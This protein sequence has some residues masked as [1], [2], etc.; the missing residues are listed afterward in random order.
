MNFIKHTNPETPF[1]FDLKFNPPVPQNKPVFNC[2]DKF[3][4]LLTL[5]INKG[6]SVSIRGIEFSLTT[7]FITEDSSK[8]KFLTTPFTMKLTEA[9]KIESTFQTPIPNCILPHDIQTYHGESFSIRHLVRIIVKKSLGHVEHVQEIIAYKMTPIITEINP[10]CVSVAVSENL[11]FDLLLGRRIFDIGAVIIG[12]VH[13]KLVSLKI[14]QFIVSLLSQEVYEP[15]KG[16][17]KKHKYFIKT[18]EISDGAPVKGEIIPFRLFLDPLDI[19]PSNSDTENGYS[20]TH[21]LHFQIM[22]EGG[23]KYFK[24]FQINLSK[25]DKLPYQFTDDSSVINEKP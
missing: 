23:N 2:G 15:K 7:E 16:K 12:A 3:D 18:W 6:S 10:L 13:F 9:I 25:W 8:P 20:A 4:I 22:T 19:T 11:R 17:P 21:F 24:A 5:S 14:Q 1:V